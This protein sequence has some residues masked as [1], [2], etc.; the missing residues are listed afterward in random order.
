M[1]QD[2]FI[3]NIKKIADLFYLL[4]DPLNFQMEE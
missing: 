4:N 2:W 3:N 1:I